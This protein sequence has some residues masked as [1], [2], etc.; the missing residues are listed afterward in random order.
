MCMHV[1]R[2]HVM[3]MGLSHIHSS[4]THYTELR[5]GNSDACC[6]SR[7]APGNSIEPARHARTDEAENGRTRLG[8]LVAGSLHLVPTLL[9]FE[10]YCTVLS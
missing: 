1:R 5:S 8:D 10:T 4:V 6:S 7:Q 2:W 3:L 9:S